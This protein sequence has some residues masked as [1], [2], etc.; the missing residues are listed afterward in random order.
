MRPSSF[1]FVAIVAVA[2]TALLLGGTGPVSAQFVPV[3]FTAPEPGTAL[4]ERGLARAGRQMVV[5]ASPLASEAAIAMLRK[6]GSAVDAAIAAQLV[7]G[8]VEPQSSG[9]GGGGL[10]VVARPDGRVTTY[11]GRETAPAGTRPDRFLGADGKPM[12]FL[13]ALDGG[14]AVGTPG[15][16]A[17]LAFA[18]GRHGRLPWAELFQPAIRLAE[19]G[20]PV[21][22]RLAGVLTRWR[23]ALQRRN[24][25]HAVYYPDGEPL[26]VGAVLRNPD[27]AAS[28][29][30]LAAGGPDAFY[31]GPLG[32]ALVE[33]LAKAAT[34]SGLATVTRED[35]AVYTVLE[36]EPVCG[37]YRVWRICGMG[38]PSSGGI[39]VLQILGMLEGFDMKA[40]GPASVAGRHL[41]AEA[42]RLAFADRDMYVADPAF[43]A[44][45]VAGLTDRAYVAERARLIRPDRAT[46]G[47]A[48][49]GV[50]RIREG[51]LRFAPAP[52][53]D[54][55]STSHLSIVDGAGLAVAFTTTV[56]FAFGSGLIAGGMVLN[57]QLTDFSFAP[58]KDGLP[59]ANAPSGGK[60]PRSSMAPTLVFGPDGKLAFVLGSPGGPAIIGFVAQTV[61]ALLDW[62]L[63]P[64]A[65][66]SLPMV[67]N[68][69]GPTVVEAGAAADALAD[70]LAA[71]GH[72]VERRELTSGLNVIA[73]TARGLLGG[74]DPRRDGV[75]L[76]D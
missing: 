4:T 53:D 47:P 17:L 67:V 61:V 14:R 22:P 69:N 42:S 39:A 49:A 56:E 68:T 64:Q 28:L 11:D 48:S 75:A 19:E 40:L 51:R 9:L 60:R 45:P 18:H 59:V 25:L 31:R 24:D 27:Y 37:T 29:R 57:N 35:L 54:M 76:G 16:V 34:G 1:P 70:G 12:D 5:T 30:L 10:M 65:A 2:A 15:A 13:S 50:P 8:L 6:G 26:P 46:A 52:E 71:M 73:V 72:V 3:Q 74:S 55:P 38:P 7:L 32:A 33:R 62:G 41:L 66:V 21:P 44:V 36:R 43:V 58:V 63:D 20:F 23:Q